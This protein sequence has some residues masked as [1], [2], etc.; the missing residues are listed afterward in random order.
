MDLD[1]KARV[2]IKLLGGNPF[3][4][5]VLDKW[6]NSIKDCDKSR[7]TSTTQQEGT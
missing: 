6:L 1:K 2:E 4:V 7:E 3:L 5:E